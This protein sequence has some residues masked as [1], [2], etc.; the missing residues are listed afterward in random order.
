MNERNLPSGYQSTGNMFLRD[1]PSRAVFNPKTGLFYIE[2]MGPSD[3]RDGYIPNAVAQM[4]AAQKA[5]ADGPK[6]MP[7]P[8]AAK[9]AYLN[10]T[11]KTPKERKLADLMT[12]VAKY[13][14]R[15]HG[16]VIAFPVWL[17]AAGRQRLLEIANRRMK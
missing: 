7:M 1:T 13:R 6:L 17:S 2:S 10:R 9:A 14:E 4:A 3:W 15:K 11:A 12:F 8:F 16:D 5:M